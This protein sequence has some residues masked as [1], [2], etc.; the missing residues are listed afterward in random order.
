MITRR[1]RRPI[2]SA[3]S[4]IGLVRY[5][6][7]PKNTLERVG[8][9]TVINCH[10]DDPMVAALEVYATQ[11]LNRRAQDDKTY[12]FYFSFRHGEYPQSEVLLDCERELCRALGFE[13]H[14]RV[15]VVH[16]DTDNLHVRTQ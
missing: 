11:E 3:S 15:S 2:G 14:Q 6:L 4:Y 10:S 16:R 9:V 5:L 12:H 1:P 13:E 7:D 8:R